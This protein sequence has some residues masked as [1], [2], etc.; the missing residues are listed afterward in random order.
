MGCDRE[1]GRGPLGVQEAKALLPACVGKNLSHYTPTEKKNY[2]FHP[3][4]YF[5]TSQAT[6][7]LRD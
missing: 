7:L 5:P 3:C 2:F 4:F 6:S 1:R